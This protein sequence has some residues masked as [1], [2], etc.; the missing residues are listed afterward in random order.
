MA[1]TPFV[2][3]SAVAATQIYF[4]QLFFIYIFDEE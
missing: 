1:V 3:Y 4:L 2:L